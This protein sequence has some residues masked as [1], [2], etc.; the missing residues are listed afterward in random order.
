MAPTAVSTYPD[1]RT[2]DVA[3]K[4]KVRDGLIT[5][6]QH[7]PIY[8]ALKQYE[9]FPK[10]IDGRTVWRTEDYKDNPERWTHR[11]TSEEI[12][13]L[14][15]TADKF[16]QSGVPLTTISKASFPL[17]T[18][19]A[20]LESVRDDLVNGKGFILFKGFPVSEWG[21][22]KSAIAYMGLGVHLGHLV[23]QNGRGHVLGHV[24]DLGEDATQI[25]KVR[26]YRTNARQFFHQ[27]SSDLVGLLCLSR[28][29]SGGESDIVSVHHVYNILQHS[30]PDVV[31]TLTQPIW[32][33]DR[34][35]EV[36]TGQDPFIRAPVLY[37]EREA[38]S[39]KEPRVS[40]KWDPYYVRS[41][42]RF[43]DPPVSLIPPL[44]EEQ[45]YAM[46]VLERVCQEEALHMVLE[47]GDL[48]FVSNLHVLHARTAYRDH[49]PP[50]P[51]RHLMRLWLSNPEGEGEG[52]GGWRLPFHDSG[53][54]RRGGIQ[55]NDVAAVANL[56]AE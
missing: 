24:K 37:L 19:S 22:H 5:S 8:E 32:Y 9:D 48:Q 45:K 1:S 35:G 3:S 7:P 43:S 2:S 25:D 16:S 33:F 13:E 49:A 47:V 56:D 36:S 44:S 15:D 14:S 54:E 26:I 29:L 53:F 40:S 30:H 55:V 28:A 27:D 12:N 42:S 6:G 4:S 34:K 21:A 41:L 50:K 51:R 46:D 10:H 11:F 39:G 17:P 31:R 23:S 52:K 20:Y 18:F 38:P